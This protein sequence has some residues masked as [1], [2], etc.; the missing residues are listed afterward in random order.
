MTAVDIG[1]FR[2]IFRDHWD[3]FKE[4]YPTFDTPDYST[5]V[6]KMLDC[7]DPDKM[8]YVQYR[9]VYCGETRQ[10][11]FTCKSCFLPLLCPTADEPVV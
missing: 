8:G 1:T 4:R 6:Q 7:G 2:Q 10:L 11:A 9:C 5:A 3:A